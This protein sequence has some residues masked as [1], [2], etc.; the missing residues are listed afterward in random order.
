VRCRKR[1]SPLCFRM[2]Q[3]QIRPHQDLVIPKE[4]GHGRP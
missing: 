2:P 4:F 1:V 3:R